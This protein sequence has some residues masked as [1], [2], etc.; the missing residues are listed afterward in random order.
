MFAVCEEPN[1]ADAVAECVLNDEDCYGSVFFQASS[2][3]LSTEN[4]T[5]PSRSLQVKTDRTK[6]IDE[7]ELR[8]FFERFGQLHSVDA[9]TAVVRYY[10]LREASAAIQNCSE[11]EVAYKVEVATDKAACEFDEEGRILVRVDPHLDAKAIYHIFSTYGGIRNVQDV[12]NV[13]VHKVV[14]FFDVRSA[15]N[16]VE[17][18]NGVGSDVHAATV[19]YLERMRCKVLLIPPRLSSATGYETDFMEDN[20]TSKTFPLKDTLKS[21]PSELSVENESCDVEST[22]KA[23]SKPSFFMSRSSDSS[24]SLLE[25]GKLILGNS[26][27]PFALAGLSEYRKTSSFADQSSND[28]SNGLSIRE[29]LPSGLGLYEEDENLVS[30]NAEFHGIGHGAMVNPNVDMW[31]PVWS[32]ES[33]DVS[34]SFDGFSLLPK[35]V[36]ENLYGPGDVPFLEARYP[37]SLRFGHRIDALENPYMEQALA[38]E[39]FKRMR[40]LKSFD[41]VPKYP[42]QVPF[43]NPRT[44]EDWRPFIKSHHKKKTTRLQSRSVEELE[45]EAERRAQQQKMYALDLDR[46]RSGKDLRTTLMIKNIPNKYTQKML[47]ARIEQ[48]FKGTFDFF[49][50]PIDFKNKCNVGYGFINMTATEHILRF[51]EH[52]HEQKWD[53]FNSDKVCC[54]T[55]ARIQGRHALINHFQ[56]SNLMHEDNK[57]QPLLFKPNGDPEPFPSNPMFLVN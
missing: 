14:E 31:N 28:S 16:A 24:S 49:Y 39:F 54:V 11:K 37:G 51:V 50:L 21:I 6:G 8:L 27:P 44:A 42:S 1:V 55:Y 32:R 35:N 36:I 57:H 3:G 18:M 53:K 25:W 23:E 41:T 7:A 20:G 43:G 33:S 10:D 5:V 48:D 38:F 52:V 34:P 56:N 13:N 4:A 17:S 29:A 26:P 40:S 30:Q 19:A 12:P 2:T 47:L 15:T 9:T 22:I 46:I 45:K